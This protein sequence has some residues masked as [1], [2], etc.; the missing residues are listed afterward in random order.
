[1]RFGSAVFLCV[2]ISASALPSLGRAQMEAGIKALERA[3]FERPRV[4]LTAELALRGATRTTLVDAYRHLALVYSA[5]GEQ[6]KA[7]ASMRVALSLDPQVSPPKAAGHA[8][9]VAFEHVREAVAKL[10]LTL[11][12]ELAEDRRAVVARVQGVQPA[13]EAE[14]DLSCEGD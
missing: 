1:M 8:F 9:V 10:P 13:F 14:V 5:T 2:S 11:G 6:D 7:M 3:D 4:A 12:I